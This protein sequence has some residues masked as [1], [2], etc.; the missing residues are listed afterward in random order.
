MGAVPVAAGVVS[1]VLVVLF[2]AVVLV[3]FRSAEERA[4]SALA[5]TAGPVRP[6]ATGLSWYESAC[7]QYPHGPAGV[8]GVALVRMHAEGRLTFLGRA[9]D[10][11]VFA[12][13][14]PV[15][16]DEV[17]AALLDPPA[18]KSGRL[19][20]SSGAHDWS[21]PPWDE[22]RRRLVTDGLL[23]ERGLP[24]GIAADAP[25]VA[26][27][28][29]ARARARRARARLLTLYLVTGVVSALL[30]GAWPLLVGYV[31]AVPFLT[32]SEERPRHPR[33]PEITPAGEAAVRAARAAAP[34]SRETEVLLSVAKGGLAAAP[35]WHPFGK[36]PPAA[37]APPRQV[38]QVLQEEPPPAVD[39]DPPGLGGL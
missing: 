11:Y 10:R 2:S 19:S 39:L 34:D 4:W 6:P 8:L 24:A 29:T 31:V 7:L 16:R 35:A 13:N 21:R 32:R 26:A 38:R 36:P 9:Y 27:W 33:A 1:A 17:E 5:A 15:P 20:V 30:S 22:L 23:R 3:R 25:Q 37:S 18:R 28:R 14:D 12:V